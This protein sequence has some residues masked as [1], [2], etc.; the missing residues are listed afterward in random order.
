M[1]EKV[2]RYMGLAK[3]AGVLFTGYNTCTNYILKDRLPLVIVAEDAAENTK[4]KFESLTYNRNTQLV[5]WGKKEEMSRSVGAENS[6]VF[7]ITDAKF[8]EVIESEIRK[9]CDEML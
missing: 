2:F 4:R 3:K 7:G 1:K 5:I 8:A 9:S 6:T